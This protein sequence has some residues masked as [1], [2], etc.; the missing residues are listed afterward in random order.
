LLLQS[1]SVCLINHKLHRSRESVFGIKR[2]WRELPVAGT[3]YIYKKGS[4]D[5]GYA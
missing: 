3:G 1:K 4:I 5:T 2:G